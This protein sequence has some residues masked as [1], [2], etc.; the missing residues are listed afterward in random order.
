[1]LISNVGRRDTAL[2]A[3][4]PTKPWL[5]LDAFESPSAKQDALSWNEHVGTVDI[6]VV[7]RAMTSGG[8]PSGGGLVKKFHIFVDG[9]PY[10]PFSKV[11]E[12]R[13]RCIQ[14]VVV[15]PDRALHLI[16]FGCLVQ[17]RCSPLMEADGETQQQLSIRTFFPV[18]A[19]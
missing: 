18:L 3:A 15:V 4:D 5:E 7:P 8:G 1:V 12:S 16:A 19:S 17:V 10:G 2:A 6:E 14:T 9:Q 11:R 13:S